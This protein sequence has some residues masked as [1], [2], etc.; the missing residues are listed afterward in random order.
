M[1]PPFDYNN[2]SYLIILLLLNYELSICISSIFY[3]YKAPPYTI[4][5]L[6]YNSQLDT[7]ILYPF[8]AY[9]TPPYKTI[10]WLSI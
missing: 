1:V 3:K 5:E 10:V 9:K 6:L 2:Y 7:I 8:I 4:A